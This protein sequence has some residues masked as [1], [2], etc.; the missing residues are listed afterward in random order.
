MKDTRDCRGSKHQGEEQGK[1][2]KIT[3]CEVPSFKAYQS[4]TLVLSL[5]ISSVS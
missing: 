2:N 5:A 1:E 4:L 3:L